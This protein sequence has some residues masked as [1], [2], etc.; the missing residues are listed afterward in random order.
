M[1][2]LV[3]DLRFGVRMLLKSPGF[4]VVATLSLAL[5][6]GANTAIFTFINAVFFQSLNVREPDQ[7]M[8]LFTRDGKS[9]DASL[10]YLPLSYPNFEDYRAQNGVFTDLVAYQNVRLNLSG[11]GG[12]PQQI[13]GLI[14]SGAY[15]DLLGVRAAHGRTFLPEEDRT[16]GAAPVAV[17][18]HGL[19][20]RRFGGDASVLGKQITL[21]NQSFTVVGIA[22]E[23]FRGTFA[24]GGPQ[25]WVPMTMHEQVLTGTAR[26]WFTSRR[27]L[28]TGVL[29]RLKPGVTR[30][31]AQSALQTVARG[32][33]ETYP[34]D[35]EKRSV[36]LLPL[37]Q[38]AIDP[39]QRELFV[40]AGGVLLTIVGL[41]L[42][43]ACANIANLLLARAAVRGREMSI[44][45]ALGAERRR[46]FQQLMTESLLLA[47]LGGALGLLFAY[48]GRALLWNFRPPFLPQNGMDLSFN[49]R[50]LGFTLL[51][52]V[53]TSIL[54]GLVPA[55]QASRLDLAAE[56]KEKTG[57]AAHSRRW[58]R[59]GNLLIVFEVALSLV[60]LIGAGLFL[61][62][63]Y[64]AQQSDPGFEREKLLIV[65][66]NVGSVGMDKARG[67][68]FYRQVQERVRA[69]PGVESVSLASNGPFN[70]GFLN[71]IKIEGQPATE[72]TLY[73]AVNT[74]TP[75]YF[76]TLGI[77]LLRGRDFRETDG[78][79]AP[80]VAVVNEAMASRFFPGQ[81]VV[82]KRFAFF[83]EDTYIEIVGV[84]RDSLQGGLNETPKPLIYLPLRQDYVPAVALCV[85]TAGDPAALVKTVR[86]EVQALDPNLPLIG[87]S[88]ISEM[89]ARVLWAPRMGAVL[90]TL[91]GSLA[92]LLA[93][94]GVYG[95]LSYSVSQRTNE[96]GLR[97]ALGARPRH[98]L[99]LVLK[100]GMTL[101]GV[102]LVIG[103][104]CGFVATRLIAGLLYGVSA[105]D[106]LTFLCTPLLLAFVA[107]LAGY[108][109]ARRAARVDPL[110][111]LR[112]D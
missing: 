88:T 19:W 25:L 7:V 98:V 102:G 86:G 62:S 110:T 36:V 58:R 93:A 14:V 97:M 106:P 50:V 70:P 1:E 9:S 26:E 89:T 78:P 35:N 41:V 61:H 92:L 94:I 17:L 29:G 63:L 56:L 42:L 84:A 31:Q 72:K 37:T 111:A 66:F 83:D 43:I 11:D 8:E 45:L 18:S 60:A 107:L 75:S 23:N 51:L 54:F 105:L 20:Q 40:K 24:I 65:L 57:R 27:A 64:V 5:G 100:Q 39:N 80:P 87:V 34:R 33:E 74:V 48:W 77:P 91:F 47:L 68:E 55:L 6:I 85:R 4:T 28:T 79:Q 10:S 109:P 108:L 82:G 101:V 76:Q 81:E 32:L 15:F 103:L 96:I 67:E 49:G 53:L 46:I 38:S 16:P 21:N 95:V 69:V 73:S 90:L 59:I 13:Q 44:R 112:Y 71:S 22:P 104:G 30:E 12:E 3:Q 2:S 52:C 99:W